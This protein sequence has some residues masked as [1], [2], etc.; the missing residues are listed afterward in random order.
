MLKVKK[1]NVGY[2]DLQVLWETSFTVK[3]GEIF[4]LVG[5]NGAGKTTT[6]KTI[7]GLLKPFSG[8]IKFLDKNIHGLHP[9]KIVEEGIIHVP[10][11]R[12]L[13]PGMT[14]LENLE[15]GAYTKKARVKR[16]DSLENVFNLFPILRERKNQLAGTLSGGE[17]QMLAIARGLMGAPRILMMDE[18][19][20][21]LAPKI[22][23]KIF[24]AIK[25]INEN[26]V[27]I[28]L[29]EQNV[30][31]ALKIAERAAVLESGRVVLEGRGEELLGDEHVKKSYLGR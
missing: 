25:E 5:S 6:L 30:Y 23:L 9:Y 4:A 20:L 12:R 7:S 21:G 2:G 31:H 13:F 22:V 3:R 15:L 27:T 1:I 16:R 10:E 29:V 26:G 24:D 14:V 28:L 8:L 11:G 18:P 19:S 17:Q